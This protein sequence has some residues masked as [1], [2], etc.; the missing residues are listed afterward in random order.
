MKKNIEKNIRFNAVILYIISIACIMA[1]IFYINDLRKDVR[2]QK[3][4]IVEQHNI[5]SMANELVYAVN[6]VQSQSAK[7]LLSRGKKNIDSYNVA[8]QNIDSL[9]SS[10]ILLR[11]DEEA[12]LRRI[13]DLLD[14]QTK[15]IVSLS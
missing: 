5:L 3:Q 12:N 1:M 2:T 11:P 10:I 9:I 6:D 13:E 15:H 4:N 14:R 8:L 7:F